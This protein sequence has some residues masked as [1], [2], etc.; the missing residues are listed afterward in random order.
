MARRFRL[1]TDGGY[2]FATAGQIADLVEA[3]LRGTFV[4]T[5]PSWAVHPVRNCRNWRFTR[6]EVEEVTTPAAPDTRIVILRDTDGRLAPS[7]HPAE[8]TDPTDANLEANRLAKR[9]GKTF[10]VW[11]R[12][13]VVTPPPAPKK[14]FEIGQYVRAIRD[15][16]CRVTQHPV[17]KG[18]IVRVA[19]IASNRHNFNSSP[20]VGCRLPALTTADFELV[21]D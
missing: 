1:V 5:H 16:K 10:E 21:T 15:T 6:H 13:Y 7:S 8:H 4:L 18:Q 20:I 19:G 3:E 9:H 2:D 14:C 12:D 11:K 17:A